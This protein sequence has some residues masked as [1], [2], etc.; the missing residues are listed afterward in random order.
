MRADAILRVILNVP[1]KADI[2]NLC[3]EDKFVRFAAVENMLATVF[4]LKVGQRDGASLLVRKI[5]GALENV[6]RQNHNEP[7]RKQSNPSE[8]ERNADP[9][10]SRRP[11]SSEPV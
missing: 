8:P 1:L 2:L 11:S 7:P 6:I 9:S 3:Q 10:C 5:E 4:A